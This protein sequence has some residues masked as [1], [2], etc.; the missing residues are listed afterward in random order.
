MDLGSALALLGI[1]LTVGIVATL[2][3]SHLSRMVGVALMAHADGLDAYRKRRSAQLAH[4]HWATTKGR[5]T[6]AVAMAPAKER[7]G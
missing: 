3:S 2:A 4:W 1:S 7:L 5:R 6:K